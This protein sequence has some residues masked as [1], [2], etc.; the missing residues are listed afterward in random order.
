M[1]ISTESAPPAGRV[2]L[3]F[4]FARR[5]GVLVH[6]MHED[7]ARIWH[8]PGI[9]LEAL[10]ALQALLLCPLRLQEIPAAEFDQA[11]ERRYAGEGGEAAAAADTLDAQPLE[12]LSQAL[13]EPQDLLE[14]ADDAPVIP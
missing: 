5:H 8:R 2:Q 11:L 10:T 3:P 9:G 13:G 14:S 4:A 6:E 12:D 1:A 7:G